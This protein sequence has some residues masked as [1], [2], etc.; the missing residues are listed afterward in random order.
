MLA[1]ALDPRPPQT[2][3]CPVAR[4]GDRQSPWRL[5]LMLNRLG[6]RGRRAALRLAFGC[7]L[8][9]VP[10]QAEPPHQADDPPGGVEGRLPAPQPV[11]CR[12][13]ERVVVVMPRLAERGKR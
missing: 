10:R 2:D 7:D 8:D 4:I 12:A 3:A 6:G 13:R 9:D 1:P 5:D 11:E